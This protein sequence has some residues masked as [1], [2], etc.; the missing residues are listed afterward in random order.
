MKIEV[1]S[2]KDL[3]NLVTSQVRAAQVQDASTNE[4]VEVA[5]IQSTKGISPLKKQWASSISTFA[6]ITVDLLT[7]EESVIVY[8]AKPKLAEVIKQL[9][10]YVEECIMKLVKVHSDGTRTGSVSLKCKYYDD[11]CSDLLTT[12]MFEGQVEQKLP[13]NG[14]FDDF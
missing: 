13:D 6:G 5:S 1:K 9:E 12:D 4:I 11:L 3:L 2:I 10:S 7:G 14:E 8:H